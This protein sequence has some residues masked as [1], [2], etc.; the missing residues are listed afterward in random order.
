M[1]KILWIGI[2]TKNSKEKPKA[3]LLSTLINFKN[4]GVSDLIL[5]IDNIG[6]KVKR[7]TKD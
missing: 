1:L 3:T 7:R 5:C 2:L 6:Q 4:N